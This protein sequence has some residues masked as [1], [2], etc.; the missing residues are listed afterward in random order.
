MGRRGPPP[1][2]TQLRVVRGNPSKTAIPADEPK[3]EEDDGAPPPGLTGL[4]L[5][6]WIDTVAVL[7][8]MGVWTAADRYT[9]E[10]YCVTYAQWQRN[11][12]VVERAGDVIVFKTKDKNGNPYMQVSPFATQMARAAEA[13][14][15]IEQQ[16]GLT[17]SSRTQVRLH[18][19]PED[20]PF[21]AFVKKRGG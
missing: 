18:A 11:R 5:D 20:D 15:R 13:L 16:Y 7:K 12:E 4:A 10:R 2:P 3:P 6:K 17:P 19:R 8:S 14:L 1:Q 9:W 21:E